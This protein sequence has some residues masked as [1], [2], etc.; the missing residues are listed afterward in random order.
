M[1]VRIW[2][3]AAACVLIAAAAAAQTL[4]GT[5]AQEIPS[6]AELW[7][8][9]ETSRPVQVT[10]DLDAGFPQEPPVPFAPQVKLS[11][12][13]P[14]PVTQPVRT[15]RRIGPNERLRLRFLV[16]GAKPGEPTVVRRFGVATARYKDLTALNTRIESVSCNSVDCVVCYVLQEAA[17]V[18]LDT[19]RAGDGAM[20]R[21]NFA[22]GPRREGYQWNDP[23]DQL[24]DNKTRAQGSFNIRLDTSRNG[25]NLSSAL[26]TPPF[27]LPPGQPRPATCGGKPIR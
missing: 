27:D 2:T 10:V 9:V 23:W 7:V 20:V 4:V 6:N 13:G 12:D 1:I 5:A 17:E 26:S 22:S 14:A 3:V 16:S 25:V 18:A 15:T 11:T 21:N 24:D 8:S 19:R